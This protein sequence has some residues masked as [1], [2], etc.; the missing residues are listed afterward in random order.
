M[1]LID[2]S[3]EEIINVA[4]EMEKR[5]EG[6]FVLTMK[7]KELQDKFWDLYGHQWFRA[8]TLC[9][10]TKFLRENQELLNGLKESLGMCL[11]EK[12]QTL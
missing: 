8:S 12:Q 9:I 7:D 11:N 6:S 10:G 5:I 3:P 2:N 1:E 4:D